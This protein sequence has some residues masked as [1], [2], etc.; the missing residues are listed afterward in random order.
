[1]YIN[2]KRIRALEERE[3]AKIEIF[4]ERETERLRKIKNEARRAESASALLA[5]A[6]L[7]GNR[8]QMKIKR[9]ESG[10]PAFETYTGDLSLSHSASLCV[11]ALTESGRVS[12][13]IEKIDESRHTKDVA[14]RFFSEKEKEL[15]ANASEPTVEF[16]RIWTKREAAA[17]CKGQNLATRLSDDMLYEGLFIKTCL[18]EH[19]TEKYCLSTAS[20]TE[21]EITILADKD[22]T[23]KF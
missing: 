14:A 11:A 17:K 20:D 13:D 9:E 2:I 10:R 3:H 19:N 15:V 8:S 16:F 21:D 4:G 5:L 18:V 22:I 12:V 1:M 7:A 6:E 23:F